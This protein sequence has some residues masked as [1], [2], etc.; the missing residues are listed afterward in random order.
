LAAGAIALGE[1]G[2][3]FGG[4]QR[5][6]GLLG[7]AHMALFTFLSLSSLWV[8]GITYFALACVRIEGERHPFGELGA[9]AGTGWLRGSTAASRRYRRL[10]LSWAGAGLMVVILATHVVRTL[11]SRS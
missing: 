2:L 8:F 7:S 5:T 4:A 10:A 1:L 11:E 9:F 3:T 6:S